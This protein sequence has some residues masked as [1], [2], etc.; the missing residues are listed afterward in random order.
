MKKKTTGTKAR[1]GKA[2][3]AAASPAAK[4][5]GG[6]RYTKKGCSATKTGA[7]ATAK[8]L[9]DAGKNARIVKGGPGRY[10]VYARG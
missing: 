5:F 1:S 8:K 6:K 10:C 3:K 2:G 9:R 7:K 4:T